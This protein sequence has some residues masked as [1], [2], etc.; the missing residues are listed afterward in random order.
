MLRTSVERFF[1]LC[2]ESAA[3]YPLAAAADDPAFLRDSAR[4]LRALLLRHPALAL[5]LSTLWRLEF[6]AEPASGH[7]A[8]RAR[9]RADLARLEPSLDK[10]PDKASVLL[11]GHALLGDP[12]ARAATEDR[13]LAA[14]P[15]TFVAF[16]I[17]ESRFER[18][19]PGWEPEATFEASRDW[20][21][22]WPDYPIPWVQRL[23][24]LRE[25]SGVPDS[26]AIRTGE[27]LLRALRLRP[28]D[29]SARRPFPIQ[30]A[31]LW[32][33]R[34][35]RLQEVLRLADQAVEDTDRHVRARALYTPK[36]LAGL[37]DEVRWLGKPLRVEALASMGRREEAMKV[38]AEM[39]LASAIPA[40][41]RDPL[42]VANRRSLLERARAGLALAD[43]STREALSHYRNAVEGFEGDSRAMPEP[44]EA[45]RRAKLLLP[46]SDGDSLER[47]LAGGEAAPRGVSAV[48]F[49]RRDRALPP[50][51]LRTVEGT[52]VSIPDPKAR[53]LVAVM[54]ATW[55]GPCREE[56]PF[57]QALHERLGRS[58]SAA[59]VTLNV[60]DNPG[61]VVPFLRERR[62]TFPVLL[63][64]DYVA[65]LPERSLSVPRTWI[66]SP[67]GRVV[68]ESSGFVA[69]E[70]LESWLRRVEG[71]L[72]S[73][74]GSAG[75]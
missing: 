43:G 66:V 73:V 51:A 47:W 25:T 23:G 52:T 57:V 34:G 42:E 44:R 60:D 62:F 2:P 70:P 29:V 19:H 55:C 40:G 61:L 68:L 37:L 26:E 6:E 48:A 53:T 24:A 5:L 17:E 67:E 65:S 8:I 64:K 15:G 13:I 45:L 16:E 1:V 33:S 31:E 20:I 56:L 28:L 69:G 22:R 41:Y 27:G 14:N 36:D 4:R 63:A 35:V 9:V 54:W 50:A 58:G 30:V 39:E 7:E 32:I 72:A 38:L 3:A 46:A 75:P 49:E 18:L 21:R 59:L 74:S 10:D 12:A 11:E 71:A